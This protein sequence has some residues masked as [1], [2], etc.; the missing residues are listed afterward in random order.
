VINVEECWWMCL[1]DDDI[2]VGD[3]II[4]QNMQH[5]N[6]TSYIV[7]VNDIGVYFVQ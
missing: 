3:E 5:F 2:D 1:I 7:L 6:G 4:S